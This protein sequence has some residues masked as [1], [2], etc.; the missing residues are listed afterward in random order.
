[1]IGDDE[2][3]QASRSW[4]AHWIWPK[5]EETQKNV[6]YYFR[7]QFE[8][9]KTEEPYTLYITADT[10]Y[11]V[12]VNGQAVRY[13]PPLCVSHY[14]YYD[15]YEVNAYLLQ[16]VNCIAVEVYQLGV[17]QGAI[18]GLLCELTDGKGQTI[19]RSDEI[20]KAKRAKAWSSHTQYFRMSMYSPF[21]EHL[22]AR[23]VPE[24]WMGL[25]FSDEDWSPTQ[26]IKGI[27]GDRPPAVLP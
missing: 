19:V 24:G 21:Q 26:I 3:M 11:R 6:Y 15:V 25:D 22:D 7:K 5:E 8:L 13:G 10:R 14:Q 1:L 20:W 27:W 18:G 2:K 16:G 12:F 17:A 4:N 9:V 23:V